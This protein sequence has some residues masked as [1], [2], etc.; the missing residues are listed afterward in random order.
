MRIHQSSFLR[1]FSV[2][3]ALLL[4]IAIS[5]CSC[6]LTP[7]E[8]SSDISSSFNDEELSDILD[9]S[10][11]IVMAT[12][13]HG[14]DNPPKDSNE[15][16]IFTYDGGTF[17]MPYYVSATG[18]ATTVG[19]LLFINGQPQPYS[20]SETG[21]I[22]YCHT[23]DM[24]T[25]GITQKFSF[26]FT[27]VTGMAGDTL[28]IVIA[29]IYNPTFKPDMMQTSGYGNYH[30]ILT[31]S[32]EIYFS[33]DAPKSSDIDNTDPSVSNLSNS[34][35]ELTNDFLNIDLL[36]NYGLSAPDIES[37]DSNVYLL[38]YLDG[39]NQN[40]NYAVT[41]DS[42]HVTIYLCGIPNAKYEVIPYLDHSPIIPSQK[43][44]LKKG[45]I[46]TIDF[47]IQAD[48]LANA[49]TFYVIASPT[50]ASTY[51]S[52]DIYAPLIKSPSILLYNEGD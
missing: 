47:E 9:D 41:E 32:Y 48:A 3:I 13:N 10:D 7:T 35:S 51:N 6:S 40:S 18:D 27:P 46:S 20:L 12:I 14:A 25:T 4:S 36:S 39:K 50:E 8:I 34:E 17:E 38:V 23:M 21:S 1:R 11:T 24:D 33:Q 31:A 28:D 43:V 37:L 5:F 22:S 30:Q 29:S 26:F 16:V 2:P 19:F 44:V 15:N 49:R 42:V 52:T 45:L